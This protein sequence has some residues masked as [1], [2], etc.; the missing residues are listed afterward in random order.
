[1]FR[2][3]LYSQLY[4][5]GTSSLTRFVTPHERSLVGFT[6]LALQL[7]SPST[8]SYCMPVPL[9]T[10]TKMPAARVHIYLTGW[11]RGPTGTTHEGVVQNATNITRALTVKSTVKQPQVVSRRMHRRI[12]DTVQFSKMSGWR[13]L[14]I[15][16]HCPRRALLIPSHCWLVIVASIQT[17]STYTCGVSL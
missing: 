9:G 5:A 8:T 11:L 16:S 4:H 12:R 7:A 6:V 15:E 3:R 1:M 13:R 2:L 10:P 14:V 17:T